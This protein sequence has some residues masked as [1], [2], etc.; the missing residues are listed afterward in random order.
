MARIQHT[1][2]SERGTSG[3]DGAVMG[4]ERLNALARDAAPHE[5]VEGI[6]GPLLTL[7]SECLDG[8]LTFLAHAD[9]PSLVIDRAH[10]R[11]DMGLRTG[12][13]IPLG[14]TY[15]QTLLAGEAPAL[16]VADAAADPHFAALATTR[17]LGIGA[18]CGVPL[19]RADGRLYGTLCT[20]HPQARGF[21]EGELA[22]LG[23]AGD[24]AMRAIEAEERRTDDRQGQD[25]AAA[26]RTRA[27]YGAMAGGVVLLDGAGAVIN[28][29]ATAENLLGVPLEEMRG[30]VLSDL[31]WS[32]TQLDGSPLP[33]AERPALA[34]LRTG[35]PQRGV[36]V[37]LT[38]PDGE[39]RI[40][41]IDAA[42]LPA[43]PGVDEGNGAGPRVVVSYVD[44]TAR[45]AAEEARRASEASLADAQ[46]IGH[47]GNWWCDTA[48]GAAYWSDELYHIH[49][50]APG[51]VDLADQ[52]PALTH[53]EDRARV[54][55]WLDAALAGRGEPRLAHRIVRPDG[56]VRHVQQEI[57]VV[58]DEEDRVRRL[59]GIVLDMTG[60]ARVEE[61]LRASERDYR[62]LM[63][64]AADG[65]FLADPVGHILDANVSAC[66]LLGYSRDEL[67]AL[68]LVDVLDP[69]DLAAAPTRLSEIGAGKTGIYD[70]WLRRKDGSR[71][72]VEVSAKALD[73]GRLQAIVRDSTERTRAA[74][75]LRASAAALATAQEL[76]HLGSWEQDLASGA[77]H[78]SDEA[79]RLL[80]YAPGAVVPSAACY[81]AA[82]HPDDRVHVLAAIGLTLSTG[83][84]SNFSQRMVGPDG[85]VRMVQSEARL[86]RDAAGAPLRLIGTAL[87][88]TARHAM[89]EALR[90]QALYD[91]LTDLPN[92]A[93][94][95]ER[96]A[97]ALGDAS[98]A[99]APLALL[100][101]DLDRFKEVNDTFGHERGDD[102]L[103]AAADRLRGAVRRGDTVAR[104]GGDEFA[105]LLPGAD[106]G[107]AT[108]VAADIRAALD[109]SLHVAGQALR[110]GVSVGIA[111]APLH[112]ADGPTLLRHAAVAMD[113]AKRERLD[114]AV[115]D[116]TQN[117]HSPERLARV[118]ELRA[119]IE[120]GALTLH[121]QPQ[122]DLASGRV[123]R[124]EA[125]VRWPHPERGLIPPDQ[126]IP[127][128]EQTGLIAPLTEWVLGEAVRQAQAWQRAGVPLTVSV[129]LSMWNLHDRVL[130]DRVAGLLREHG[131]PAARLRL[132][133][134]ESALMAGA[135]RALDVLT[136]LM[137]LGVG[138]AV[139][140]FGAGY[141][142]LAY[143][144][145]LPVD[146]LKID[147]GFVR[148]MATDATDAAIV[149][150]T[151]DLGH[152]LGLRVVAEG[153]ED[154]AT[155]TVLAGMG[156][157][158]AQ[159][160]Y[161]ARP[162][163]PDALTRW[164]RDSAWAIA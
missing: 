4:M 6:V 106:V 151:V 55:A 14:D 32:V 89:E 78:W 74:E 138:L 57:E 1:D 102:L 107:G 3:Q 158:V 60:R 10:D 81:R 76:V 50:Y 118:G 71:V 85:A 46:R 30:R 130:P 84:P 100:L 34:A 70:L 52:L 96:V 15:C 120:E 159:G 47:L 125:L 157:D 37:R 132:E 113:V 72:P 162:L 21:N 160:Y 35:Q 105:V 104:L 25:Q 38:R 149:A 148:A 98:A 5:G 119:A 59:V 111:L 39:H 69:T 131:L 26:E 124:V 152:A 24:I 53:P 8:G 42:P 91:A 141:S 67:R 83:A 154:Q 97:A 63:E 45:V 12:D 88:V 114:H 95:H 7:L 128:A 64:Q 150:S 147:K 135:E 44:V 16:V 136:R 153:I 134:T 19:R 22:L 80:G 115:Y 82:L 143:L 108:R 146:E 156:C 41:Q 163:P 49:G 92:R 43:A 33:R 110:M 65:I 140:D 66:A 62:A 133:L 29:N 18:Y 126:F 36:T 31:P 155:W 90:H 121:Y 51:A 48:T 75:E 17:D 93:L 73:D 77:L 58:C 40:V 2:E 28:A 112:G 87:D 144:K 13:V 99:P 11:A 117:K 27:I 20:L 109:A 68:E 122:V 129:N 116:P 101:L 137:G 123:R 127:L 9:G 139:D 145:R 94:L 161:L 103:R 23:R 56:A 54:R 164:L 61:A 86:V 142:S 79:Y